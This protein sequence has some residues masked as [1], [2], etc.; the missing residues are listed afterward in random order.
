MKT[1][2]IVHGGAGAWQSDIERLQQAMTVCIEAAS[3]GQAVLNQAGTAVDAV[4]AAVRVLEDSPILNAGHGSYPNAQGNIEMDAL[5]MDGKDLNLGAIAAVQ[6]VRSPISLARR[7][8][9]NC[10]HALL[11]GPGANAFADSIGFPGCEL[12][13]LLV[14]TESHTTKHSDTLGD[15][16]GAVAIDSFGNLAAATSTGGTM[17]KVPGRVGDSPLVGCGGYADNRTAAVSATGSGE[18]L[19]KV[20]ISKQ[21]CDFVGIGLSAKSACESAIILLDERVKGRGGVIAIDAR[22]QIGFAYNTFAMPHAF[23]IG[24]DDINSG[25]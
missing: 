5:I 4:E 7:V 13:D 15:T 14:D 1:A 17:N 16:V 21:V 20:V 11:V 2:I 19:M 25:R 22:G 6:R 9:E 12:S 8:M 18:D 23:A 3:V 24:E 10:D